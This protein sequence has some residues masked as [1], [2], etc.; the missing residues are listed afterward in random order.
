MSHDGNPYQPTSVMG[1]DMAIFHG[2]S[3]DR[4]DTGIPFI[5]MNMDEL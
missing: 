3:G 4:A 1:W 2:S 5:W